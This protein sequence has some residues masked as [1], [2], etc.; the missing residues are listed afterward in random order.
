MKT[1]IKIC[2]I[3]SVESACAAAESGADFLGFN[4]VKSSK[5]Y[6][7]PEK[8]KEIIDKLP[9]GVTKVGIFQNEEPSMINNLIEYL[10]LDHVQFHG[11][12]TKEFCSQIYKAGI[13]KA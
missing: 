2:G 1:Y 9:K 8:A 6:I 13:I 7:D 3:R 5:R 11:E 4:F 10:N 12:E